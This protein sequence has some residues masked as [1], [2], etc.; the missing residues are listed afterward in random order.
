[1]LKE[2]AARTVQTLH[3]QGLEA[4]CRKRCAFGEGRGGAGGV[5]TGVFPV[6]AYYVAFLNEIG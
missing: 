3:Q 1:M 4:L 2:T 6:V 5:G